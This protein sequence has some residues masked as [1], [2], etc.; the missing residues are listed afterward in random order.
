[1]KT[2]IVISIDLPKAN[3]IGD[4]LG[5]ID[6]PKVPYF[7]GTCRVVVGTDV[8]DVIKFLDEE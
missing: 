7:D 6:P 1:M 2:L 3:L 5:Y 4:V 8:D